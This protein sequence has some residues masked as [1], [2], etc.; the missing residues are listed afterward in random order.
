MTVVNRG[1]RHDDCDDGEGL[2]VLIATS[3]SMSCVENQ[4]AR[5]GSLYSFHIAFISFVSGYLVLSL[6]V[7]TRLRLTVPQGPKE[8]AP[9]SAQ[10]TNR[11]TRL[12]RSRIGAPRRARAGAPPTR[13]GAFNPSI[14]QQRIN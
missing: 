5:L 8:H 13:F 3:L 1:R 4:S 2:R 11:G 12:S 9:Q 10:R 14:P 6:V 7:C